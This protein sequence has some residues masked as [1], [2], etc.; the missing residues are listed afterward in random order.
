LERA[1][2]AHTNR[3]HIPTAG[4]VISMNL[5]RRNLTVGQRATA[6]LA[7]LD[8]EK[9]RAKEREAGQ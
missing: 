8:Y 1:I 7:L 9:E 2:P 4:F 6:A 3:E 5:R